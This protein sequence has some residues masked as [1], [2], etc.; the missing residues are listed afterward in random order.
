MLTKK[1]LPLFIL[2]GA[3]EL[4]KIGGEER[5]DIRAGGENEIEHDHL[6]VQ[7]R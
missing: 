7:G 6:A 1:M 2:E 4:G 3:L 5:A